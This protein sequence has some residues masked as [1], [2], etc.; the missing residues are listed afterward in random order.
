MNKWCLDDDGD[1]TGRKQVRCN[2]YFHLYWCFPRRTMKKPLSF[3]KGCITAYLDPGTKM[4][5][6]GRGKGGMRGMA[7]FEQ[8]NLCLCLRK[9]QRKECGYIFSND[10]EEE[11]PRRFQQLSCWK[12]KHRT[13]D[14]LNIINLVLLRNCLMIYGSYLNVLSFKV[15]YMCDT[16]FYSTFVFSGNWNSP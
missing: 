14:I 3:I 10:V 12:L 13:D 15:N 8:P 4:A 11:E 6:G 1:L 16:A 9:V 7:K 2:W 5:L